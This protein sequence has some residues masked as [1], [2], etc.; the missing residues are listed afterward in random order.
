MLFMGAVVIGAWDGIRN[1]FGFFW[2]FARSLA[3]LYCMEVYD[4]FFFD[5]FLFCRSNFSLIFIRN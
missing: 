4:I 1:D 5:R 3:M 2:F